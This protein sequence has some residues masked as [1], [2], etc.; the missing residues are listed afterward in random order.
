MAEWHDGENGR[1]VCTHDPVR[2]AFL[3]ILLLE[4]E[5]VPRNSVGDVFKT[6]DD[7]L[8]FQEVSHTARD[9]MNPS[10]PR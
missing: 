2:T 10:F 1:A 8:G 6:V 5:K 9:E 4:K 3:V 7:I